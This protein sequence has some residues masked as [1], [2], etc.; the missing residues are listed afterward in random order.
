LEE[1]YW[2]IIDFREAPVDLSIGGIVAAI[3]LIAGAGGTVIG[4]KVAVT[5]LQRAHER[6][7]DAVW[8]AIDT[9]REKAS[10]VSERLAKVEAICDLKKREGTC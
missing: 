6:F 3:G 1:Q 10:L 8:R 5:L 2:P 9:D 4:S 7:E